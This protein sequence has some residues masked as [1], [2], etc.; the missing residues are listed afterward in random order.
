MLGPVEE[1][2]EKRVMQLSN[3]VWGLNLWD[4]TAV[5]KERKKP[6]E[7]DPSLLSYSA[8]SGSAIP[9]TGDAHL[10][11]M[12][13]LTKSPS[14]P[15]GFISLMLV[16][17]I[18]DRRGACLSESISFNWMFE[19]LAEIA[20]SDFSAWRLWAR[21]WQD[22]ATT[23]PSAEETAGMSQHSPASEG[24]LHEL[25]SWKEVIKSISS[26]S[27]IG[28][29]NGSVELLIFSLNQS[30]FAL[31]PT[32]TANRTSGEPITLLLTDQP[33]LFVSFP[34]SP[35]SIAECCS[36]P[37][38]LLG[39]VFTVSFVALGVLTLCKFYLQGYRAFMNDPAMNR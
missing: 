38:S 22:S 6:A 18:M 34:L 15:A 23:W 11:L 37:Y 5:A 13:M 19:L 17:I 29:L 27:F 21:L 3:E 39:L 24:E 30:N 26:F 36:T 8:A 10:T 32:C 31:K 2:P 20:A 1:Q 28:G 14:L 33:F 12:E 35:A 4:F 25:S 16:C 9:E 7:G